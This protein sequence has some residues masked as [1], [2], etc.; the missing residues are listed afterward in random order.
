MDLNNFSTN[1]LNNFLDTVSIEQK[2][3]FLLDDFNVNVLNYNNDN[4]TNEFLDFLACNSFV[5]H[6]L[7]LTRVTSHSKK[8]I[9]NILSYIVSPDAIFGNLTLTILITFLNL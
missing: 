8:L 9:D 6:I 4:P 7:Q 5:P 2:S 1:Y 3:V